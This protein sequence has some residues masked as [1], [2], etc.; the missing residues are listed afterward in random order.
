MYDNTYKMPDPKMKSAP[1]SMMK[2]DMDMPMGNHGMPAYVM[3]GTQTLNGFP[4]MP[5]TMPSQQMTPGIPGPVPLMPSPTLVNQNYTQG[6]LRTKIGKRVRIEFLVGTNTFVDRGG[7]L[8]EVGVS[9]VVIR[10]EFSG[11]RVMADLYSIKF[12]TFFD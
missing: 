11:S 12:V 4:V 9:Y 3:P 10:D 8:E 6:F 5:G 2:P 1:L 7:I